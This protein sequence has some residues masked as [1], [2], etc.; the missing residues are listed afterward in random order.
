LTRTSRILIVVLVVL[1]ALLLVAK[2]RYAGKAPVKLPTESCDA[3]LWRHVYEKNRLQVIEA[4]TAAEGRVT[5]VFESEDGD[6]HIALDPRDKAVLNLMNAS[7]AKRRL[8]VEVICH[9]ASQGESQAA[10]GGYR[11]TVTIPKVGD[12]VRVTGAYVTD[13]DNGWNEIHPVSSIE[14]LQ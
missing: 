1:A 12:E 6:L 3:S 13:R 11:S 8:I 7:H 10:C 4:C 2:L 5:S 9:H 14:V